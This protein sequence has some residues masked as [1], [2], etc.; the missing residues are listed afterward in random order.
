VPQYKEINQVLLESEEQYNLRARSFDARHGSGTKQEY[1]VL[2][3]QVM[4]EV[5]DNGGA[6]SSTGSL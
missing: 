4:E 5:F 2:F 1:K 6:E 3:D